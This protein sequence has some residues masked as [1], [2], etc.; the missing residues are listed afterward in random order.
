MPEASQP[1]T[2]RDKQT[3]LDQ[4]AHVLDASTLALVT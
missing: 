4:A 3:L 2:V 1:R